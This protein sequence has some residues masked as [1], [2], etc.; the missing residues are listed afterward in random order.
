MDRNVKQV[1]D[2]VN[3]G[4]RFYTMNGESWCDTPTDSWRLVPGKGYVRHEPDPERELKSLRERFPPGTPCRF[5]SADRLTCPGGA[6]GMIRAWAV[7]GGTVVAW[8]DGAV[9]CIQASHV[10]CHPAPPR[11]EGGA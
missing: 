7:V 6:T 1:E 5:W 3:E 2:L 11:V 4:G 9:S 8:I 10:D